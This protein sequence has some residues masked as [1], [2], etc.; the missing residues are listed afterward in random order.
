MVHSSYEIVQANGWWGPAPQEGKVAV[1]ACG[2]DDQL[3]GLLTI[4]DGPDRYDVLSCLHPAGTRL[5][6]AEVQDLPTPQF[7]PL[8]DPIDGDSSYEFAQ[9][10]EAGAFVHEA[11]RARHSYGLDALHY[12]ADGLRH[13]ILGEPL[14]ALTEEELSGYGQRSRVFTPKHDQPYTLVPR[15]PYAPHGLWTYVPPEHPFDFRVRAQCTISK[16]A[17][18]DITLE[19]LAMRAIDIRNLHTASV[20]TELLTTPD[21]W[22]FLPLIAGDERNDDP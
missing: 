15:S 12:F 16:A 17:P 13:T 10:Q 8:F 9:V 1:A 18:L 7:S 22:V 19:E 6:R 3:L 2:Y 14:V 21:H 11:A 5:V 4:I 20:T